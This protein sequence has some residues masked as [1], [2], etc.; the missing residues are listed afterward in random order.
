MPYKYHGMLKW[1]FPDNSTMEIKFTPPLDRNKPSRI[2]FGGG[3][4]SSNIV[5]NKETN[6]QS[7]F[8]LLAWI[9]RGDEQTG[10]AYRVQFSK[11]EDMF[12]QIWT[13]GI[14]V[15]GCPRLVQE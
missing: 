8:Y 14:N 5:G 9:R 13:A 12:Y 3:D 4:G 11:V 2:V 6:R 1:T 15:W 7:W 10:S